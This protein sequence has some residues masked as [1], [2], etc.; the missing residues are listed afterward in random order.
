MAKMYRVSLKSASDKKLND[1]STP[2]GL[3]AA[4][5]RVKKRMKQQDGPWRQRDRD[6]EFGP[7]KPFQDAV[8]SYRNALE[9]NHE[10][11][12]RL[13]IPDKPKGSVIATRI[14]QVVEVD[15]PS[16]SGNATPRC[17]AIVQPLWTQFPSLQY[18]GCYNCRHIANS[19]SWSEHAWADA[20]DVHAAT[21]A[22]GDQVYRWLRSNQGRFGITRVL[23]RVTGHYDHLHIDFDPDHSGTPPCA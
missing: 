15:Y 9:K 20:I 10:G 17:K 7:P 21:M 2:Q 18:W 19:S 4:M 22:Q 3:G 23:W 11:D 16:I 12:I 8:E 5:D 6:E 14:V 13:M 1:W